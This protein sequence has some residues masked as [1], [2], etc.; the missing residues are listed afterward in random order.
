M[1]KTTYNMRQ[2][3]RICRIGHSEGDGKLPGFCLFQKTG[4]QI[5]M[6]KYTDQKELERSIFGLV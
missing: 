5:L 4:A 2:N 1:K 3:M 6:F